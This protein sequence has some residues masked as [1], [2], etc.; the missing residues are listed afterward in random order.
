MLYILARNTISDL[1]YKNRI[2][3][4]RIFYYRH[5]FN[6]SLVFPCAFENHRE[7]RHTQLD[8]IRHR[9]VTR[10]DIIRSLLL[11]EKVFIDKINFKKTHRKNNP[12]FASF[13]I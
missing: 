11:H 9:K 5:F 13:R 10:F 2:C 3:S 8:T 7:N 4:K 1:K 6:C 12:I